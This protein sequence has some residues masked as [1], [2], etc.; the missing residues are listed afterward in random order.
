MNP[1]HKVAIVGGTHGNELTGAYL[2]KKFDQFPQLVERS[3]FQTLTL[4][5]NPRAFA[6]N[7]R[8]TEKDL[9]RCFLDQDLQNPLLLTYEEQRA[10][11]IYALLKPQDQPPIDV[12]IDLHST[13][14]NMGLTLILSNNH[15]FNLQWAAYLSALNQQVKVFRWASLEQD[16]PFL[17]SLCPLGGAIEVGAIA[18]GVLYADLFQ[19]TE[20]LIQA[21]LDYLDAYNRNDLP[22]PSHRLTLY[23]GIET[24]DY[25]RSD[26]G[27][28]AAMIHPQLQ[29]RDYEPLHPGDPM[30]LTFE[31]RTIAYEGASTVYPVFINEAAY[32]EKGI[33]M[34]LTV[35][36]EMNVTAGELIATR[37]G[38]E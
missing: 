31:G 10:K 36:Q 6:A 30:F 34:C 7:R 29:F 32:Y 8:Y 20:R 24:V 1:I 5:G 15:P 33:A 14:A 12:I 3:S 23:Q 27:E 13:T 9:N 26:R 35:K 2:I 11:D 38:Q 22:P 37:A 28:I 19:Q 21:L 18:Q 16:A 25:P 4:L 17:R